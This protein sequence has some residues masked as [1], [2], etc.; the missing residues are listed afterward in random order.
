MAHNEVSAAWHPALRSE[1][2]V[3][4]NAPIS[5][6]L[7]QETK[8][9]TTESAAE[10]NSPQAFIQENEFHSSSSS[11]DTD[12]SVDVQPTVAPAVMDLDTPPHAEQV[13]TPETGQENTAED[14]AQEDIPGNQQGLLQTMSDEPR[15]IETSEESAPAFGGD[16]N[17]SHDTTAPDNVMDESFLE[18]HNTTEHRE[19]NDAASWFNEQVD[20]GDHLTTNEFVNDDNQEFWGSPTNGDAG[21]DFFSQLKTQTK[22]IYI[23]PETESRYEEGVPLLDHTVESP[24]QPSVKEESQID[25]L[26]ENDGDDEGGAFFNEV[27]GSVPEEAEPSLHITRKSTTQVIGSLDASPDSPVS[28]ASPTAQEFDNILAAAASENQAKED[29]SDDDLAAKWQAELSN[30]QPEKGSE[31]DLAAR[32][33]AAL[34]DDDD[35]LLED[36]MD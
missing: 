22:P 11:Q 33:Q 27:Q 16:A 2:G 28:A 35:L 26:F 25:K 4:S 7:T 6:D 3:P 5:D 23:P 10:L 12:A 8:D 32:W 24:A 29:L 18:E 30:D 20:K 19:D 31:D 14:S 13:L 17:G 34:D 15:V 1:D 21:D 9:S 36:E